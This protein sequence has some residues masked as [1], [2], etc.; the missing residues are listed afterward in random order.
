MK[1]NVVSYL[2]KVNSLQRQKQRLGQALYN[3]LPEELSRRIVGTDV[4][5]FYASSKDDPRIQA[6]WAWFNVEIQE[7]N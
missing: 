1:L 4:D 2:Q 6:F 5:P 3:A 7:E